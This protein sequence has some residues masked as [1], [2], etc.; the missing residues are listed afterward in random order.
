MFAFLECG[1]SVAA[2]G[3]CP[4]SPGGYQQQQQQKHQHQ[5]QQQAPARPRFEII[6]APFEEAQL[7]PGETFDL[8]F[9]SPPFFDFEIYSKQPG[10]S[11]ARY[12]KL[13]EWL[14]N[15]LFASVRKVLL[16][17]RTRNYSRIRNRPLETDGSKKARMRRHC[18]PPPCRIH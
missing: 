14:V 15:F 11:V 8:V 1:V 13:E 5:H 9:T 12:P 18:R 10:Q 17:S 7:P 16:L 6:Y 3:L 4:L 2:A